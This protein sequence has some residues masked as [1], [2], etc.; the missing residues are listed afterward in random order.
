MHNWKPIFRVFDSNA[1]PSY[2]LLSTV[3]TTQ[4]SVQFESKHKLFH[5]KNAFENVACKTAAI[6]FEPAKIH[7]P[8]WT[9]SVTYWDRV[10]HIC[11][12]NLI[13]IGSD[14]GLSPGRCQVIIWT[15]TGI[16]IVYWT[17]RNTPQWNVNRNSYIY[18]QGNTFVNV[19]KWRQFCLGLNMLIQD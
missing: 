2:D 4:T 6:V 3:Q 9:H 13:T 18:I 5:L 7:L 14:N 19:C 10:T 17:T 8:R 15:N 16:H 1:W 11:V 12:G